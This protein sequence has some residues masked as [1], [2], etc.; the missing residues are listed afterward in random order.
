[1]RRRRNLSSFLP[2]FIGW[3]DVAVKD[4]TPLFR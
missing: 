3:F 1:M 2:I 4:R